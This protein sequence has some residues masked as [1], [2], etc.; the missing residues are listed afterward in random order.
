MSK[1]AQSRRR[2]LGTGAIGAASLAAAVATRRAE[3]AAPPDAPLPKPALPL[4][5]TTYMF[6]NYTLDQ[7]LAMGQRVAVDR[8]CLRSNLLPLTATAEQIA[9][10]LAKVKK[11][12]LT[13]YGGGVIYMRNQAAIDRAFEHS[14]AAGYTL[15]SISAPPTLLPAVARKARDF[16]IRAAIHNHGPEDKHYP[17]PVAIHDK[18]KGLDEHLGICHDTGHTMRAGMDPVEALLKTADRHLDVHLKDVDAPTRKGHSTELGRGI[19][20]LPRVLRALLEAGYRGVVGIEYEKHM[21]DLLPG[22]AECVGYARGALAAL[23]KE[24]AG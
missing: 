9:A 20:D 3:A 10:A 14:R 18:I 19:V 2:F 24:R 15:I 13:V 7:T 11:A 6:K 22:L 4:G 17:T 12:G 1:H 16:G 23:R 5:L 8:I 21:T